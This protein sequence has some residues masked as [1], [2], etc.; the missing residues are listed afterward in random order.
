MARH[1]TPSHDSRRAVR[2]RPASSTL[3]CIPPR[4]VFQDGLDRPPATSS[5][6]STL[7]RLL[8]VAVAPA[9]TESEGR[10]QSRRPGGPTGL[11]A[12]RPGSHRLCATSP[13]RRV[14]LR[15]SHR[16]ATA[17]V[18][19]GHDVRAMTRHPDDYAGAGTPV[20]RRRHRRRL[21]CDRRWTAATPP[22]TW[23]TPW[24][25]TTSS[26]EDAE[27]ARA[28]AGPPPTP[29]SSDRLPRRARRRRP[30]SCPPHLRTRRE[31]ERLL[32][33]AGVPVTA[34][35]AGIIVGHGGIS[36]EMTRQL[37][38]HLPAMVTPRWVHTRT[39]PIARR[40]RRPL[41]GRRPRG[42]RGRGRVFEI[43]GP[44]VLQ[45]RRDAA[46]GRRDPGPH[47]PIVP[48]PL[49]TPRLSSRWL[50]LVT[51]VDM[52][53]GRILVDSMTNEV[54]VARR[55]HPRPSCRSSRWTTTRRSCGRWAS[56]PAER[57]RAAASAA[58]VCRRG[59]RSDRGDAVCWPGGRPLA[60][61]GRPVPRD[62]RETDAAF[63]RR[64]RVVAAVAVAGAGLLGVSLSTKPG[65]PPFYGLT[66]GGRRDLGRR[67][68]G[69][70]AAAPGLDPLPRPHLRRP[71]VT[72]VADRAG[73][74]GG[75][76]RRR[77][78]RPARSRSSTG[79]SRK[80]CA[81]PDQG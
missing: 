10:D 20:R 25:P 66:L 48:V 15:R 59:A 34:L 45:L 19:A 6:L 13:H 69:V 56:G 36:W 7:R 22:T 30:T 61:A 24:T 29:G 28:F 8:V 3:H 31:V 2:R 39:Q 4:P 43:G 49:L 17:L 50:A 23:C 42:A 71:V 57:R 68:A 35:R 41:P 26:S 52:T 33:A 14:R 67:R 64:R 1:R 62:H 47:L 12:T 72:P 79:R 55:Q 76:L 73:A 58:P 65:S 38:D 9:T 77:A 78:G 74:F 44:E 18:E 51:D 40:R 54:V 80:S 5:L 37:V 75:V 53:T 63:R 46:A 27:A 21:A 16:L 11:R 81:T 70:R 60:C 32:G